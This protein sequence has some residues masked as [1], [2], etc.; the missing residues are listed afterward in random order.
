M[1]TIAAPA[2]LSPAKDKRLIVLLSCGSDPCMCCGERPSVTNPRT[3]LRTYWIYPDGQLEEEGI[4]VCGSCYVTCGTYRSL[5]IAALT[6]RQTYAEEDANLREPD[7]IAIADE[8][9][10]RI[11]R[12]LIVVPDIPAEAFPESHLIQPGHDQRG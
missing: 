4:S 5:L 12:G 1:S 3:L 6:L 9:I 7:L 11:T 10:N 8:I 2:K